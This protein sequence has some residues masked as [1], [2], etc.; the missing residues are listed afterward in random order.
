MA[1]VIAKWQDGTATLLYLKLAE[2]RVLQQT[3]GT[4][5]LQRRCYHQKPPD[6]PQGPGSNAEKRVG[7]SIDINVIEWSVMRS[8]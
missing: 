7:S 3:W 5:I 8:I 1:D 6:G 2:Q 4:S